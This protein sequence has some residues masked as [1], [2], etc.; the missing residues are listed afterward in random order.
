[1]QTKLID[2]HTARDVWSHNLWPGRQSPIEANSA[3]R[4]LGGIEMDL[5]SYPASFWGITTDLPTKKIIG[6]LSGHFGGEILV[7]EFSHHTRS[8]RTRGL[9]VDPNYRLQGIARTLMQEAENQARIEECRALWTFPR[10]TSFLAYQRLGF[11][12]AGNWL[13][14][15]DPGAGEFGPNCYAYKIINE[16]R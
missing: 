4:W 11:Q 8:F 10:K 16:H 1:M 9:W 2:F 13:G 12:Q 3:M 14:E 6:L 7:P 15:N 5:M